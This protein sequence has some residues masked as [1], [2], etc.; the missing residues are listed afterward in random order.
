MIRRIARDVVVAALILSGLAVAF[1]MGVGVGL[2]D[3]GPHGRRAAAGP[4]Q[5]AG[6]EARHQADQAL[7]LL[8]TDDQ[9]RQAYALMDL[10]ARASALEAT[11]GLVGPPVV[12]ANDAE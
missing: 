5:A 6:P 7:L 10:R 1:L 11:L 2:A 4:R 3:T 9:M 8:A 12:A